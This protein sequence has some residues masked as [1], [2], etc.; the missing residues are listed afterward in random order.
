MI[1]QKGIPTFFVSLSAADTRWVERLQCLGRIV[2]QKEY[3]NEEIENLTYFKK[4]RLINIDPVTCAR[5][6]DR[7]FQLFEKCFVQTTIS[8][9]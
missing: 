1:H 3:T 8:V 2:D 4:T 9:R 5:Y 7:R 6:F